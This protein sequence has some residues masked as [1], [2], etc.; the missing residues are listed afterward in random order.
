[1]LMIVWGCLLVAIG[2]FALIGIPIS[3]KMRD[4]WLARNMPGMSPRTRR[5]I[6][7][8]ATALVGVPLVAFGVLAIVANI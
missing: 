8:A 1:M 4:T 3:F 2:L 7:A 5:V 6:D